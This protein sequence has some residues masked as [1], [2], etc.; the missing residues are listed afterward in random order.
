MEY[1]FNHAV[2]IVVSNEHGEIVE[3]KR[4]GELNEMRAKYPQAQKMDK[5]DKKN[6]QKILA[7]L[8]NRDF[9]EEFYTTNLELTRQSIRK[10][11]TA[12]ILVIQTVNALEELDII[13]NKR[14][15]IIREWYEW[16]NPETSRAIPEHD[17]FARA[18]VAKSKEELFADHNILA[19]NSL[20][21]PFEQKNIEP[22]L[23]L[24]HRLISDFET[25]ESLKKYLEAVMEGHYPN[26][27]R[28]ATVS[29]GAK[30]ISCAGSLQR[31][32]ELPSST[33]QILGAEKALF[34]HL[35]TGAKMPKHGVIVH[36]PLIS[37]TPLKLHGK[38]ARSLSDKISIAAKVDY[39]KG[40]F[41]GDTLKESL[42]NK[43]KMEY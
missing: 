38:V 40:N 31:L 15:K 12:D 42:I 23:E 37:Q 21:A 11:V 25:R 43:F 13:I 26:I 16:H 32:S 29:I 9:F 33:V 7:N 8:K 10:S 4:I 35:K 36:H 1:F 14:A 22:I 34:R 2:A 39:F 17:A 27:T 18:I 28:V 20:G 41:V 19:E 6:I 5:P 3:I 30:L 24:A